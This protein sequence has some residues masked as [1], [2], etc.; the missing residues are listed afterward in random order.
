MDSTKSFS[1]IWPMKMTNNFYPQQYKKKKRF[2]KALK[3][4]NAYN[5]R[6]DFSTFGRI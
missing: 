3:Y 1:S 6:N 5:I 2:I 4:G